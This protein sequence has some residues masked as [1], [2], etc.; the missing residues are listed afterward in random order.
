MAHCRRRSAQPSAAYALRVSRDIYARVP[1]LMPD[2]WGAIMLRIRE[3][4]FTPDMP[5][6]AGASPSGISFLPVP[7][8]AWEIGF[9]VDDGSREVQLI[10]LRRGP[11]ASD[12]DKVTQ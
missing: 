8:T 3:L 1:E 12:G 6:D 10:A 5:L 9:R 7:P 2:D 4:Q 11:A